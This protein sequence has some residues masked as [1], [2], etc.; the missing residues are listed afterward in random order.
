MEVKGY[1]KVFVFYIKHKENSHM[2]KIKVLIAD[3]QAI[4]AE[5]LSTLLALEDDMEIIDKVENGQE[6]LNILENKTVDII[7]MDIRMPVM[8]GV[9]CTKIVCNEYPQTKVLILTT[10]DDD[11]YIKQAI[12]NGASGY[13]LKDLT[14]EKLSVAIRDVYHGNTVMHQKITQ[15]IILG[16]SK[17]S[18]TKD[19]LKTKNGEVLTSR[20]TEILKLLAQGLTNKE[21]ANRLFLSEGTVKN[22]ITLLYDKL[23]IKGRTKLMTYAIKCGLID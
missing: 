19:R 2:T 22:Y 12:K 21:I 16:I 5:G 7:L 23:D 18:S 8:N 1:D 3:D 13:M 6:V 14:A 15:K 20:E 17:E 9:E 4:L 10:Y 11:E